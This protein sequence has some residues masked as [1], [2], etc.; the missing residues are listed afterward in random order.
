MAFCG[1]DDELVDLVAPFVVGGSAAGEPTTVALDDRSSDVVRAAVGDLPGVTYLPHRAQYERPALAVKRYRDVL[2]AHVAAGVGQVRAV[3]AVPHPGLGAPWQPWARYE[4]AIHRA[5]A[6]LPLWGMCVY[7]TRTTPGDVLADAERL[8]PHMATPGGARVANPNFTDPAAV[9]ARHPATPPDPL[10][11]LPPAAEVV[12]PTP[13][14]ARRAVR[15]VSGRSGLPPAAVEDLLIAVSEA[16]GNAWA[17]GRPPVVVRAWRAPDRVVVTVS[18]QGPGP[19]DPLVGLA[20]ATDRSSGGLGLW[21]AHQLCS[22]VQ[23]VTGD[24]GFTV[25][26]T[27]RRVGDPAVP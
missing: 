9:V 26:L 8:H 18:D 22:D 7:D 14:T 2:E 19:A 5:L 20:P 13:A 4:A 21:I 11:A 23:L 12:H 1:S 24:D 27:A 10:E 17:H 16:V 3:G 15:E 25:R 6:D